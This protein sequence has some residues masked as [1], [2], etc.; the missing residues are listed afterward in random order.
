M[1]TI[2]GWGQYGR[3]VPP[4]QQLTIDKLTDLIVS[5][6]DQSNCAPFRMVSIA[7]HA[8]KDWH[9]SNVE[10]TVSF[11][12]AMTVQKVLTAAVKK[13]WDNRNMGPPPVGGVEWETRGE[14]AKHMITHAYN[15]ANR[16]VVV[17]LIRKGARCR[18]SPTTK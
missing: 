15:P 2:G 16:R 5:S 13:L 8:D 10:A 11:E 12:R 17:T 6:F 4:G 18:S 3:H 1:E 9:G 7:G 14:G